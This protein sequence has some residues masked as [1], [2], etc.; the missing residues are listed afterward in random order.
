MFASTPFKHGQGLREEHVEF[1]WQGG[2]SFIEGGAKGAAYIRRDAKNRLDTIVTITQFFWWRWGE[3]GRKL[4][5]SFFVGS[6]L[7]KVSHPAPLFLRNVKF[8]RGDDKK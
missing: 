7:A 8:C 5:N 3:V 6:S 4:K 1:L 2:F